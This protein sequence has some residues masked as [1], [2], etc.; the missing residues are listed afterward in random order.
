[1]RQLMF[2]TARKLI[3]FKQMKKIIANLGIKT[4]LII[5]VSFLIMAIIVA[6]AYFT[7]AYFESE[8]KQ[9]IATEQFAK[10]ANFAGEVD[11]KLKKPA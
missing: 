11:D 4:K 3:L 2:A 10:V 7:I 5:A 1:M 9:L 6:I 8:T